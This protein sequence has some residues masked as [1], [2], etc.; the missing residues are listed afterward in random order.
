[1]AEAAAT[2]ILRSPRQ[3]SVTF[4]LDGKA[5]PRL[6]NLFYVRFVRGS[7]AASQS[8]WNKDLGFLVKTVER[9]AISP[10]TEELNQYNKKRQVYTGYKASPVRISVY[11]TADSLCQQM[12]SEYSQYY[13]GDFG[14]SI[15]TSDF[16]YDVTTPDFKDGDGKGFGFVPSGATTMSTTTSTTDNNS[17]FFFDRIQIFQVWKGQY[18]QW[19]LIN[20]R[21]TSFD[22]DDLS[23]EDSQ[24][25]LVNM[26][27]AYEAIIMANKGAPQAMSA[28]SVLT[29]AFKDLRLS[30]DVFDVPTVN[31]SL[32]ASVFTDATRVATA[33]LQSSLVQAPSVF[34]TYD[35]SQAGGALAS[36]GNYDFGAVNVPT[37]ALQPLRS[38]ATDLSLQS[39]AN[40][41]LAAALNIRAQAQ[42]PGLQASPLSV[43]AYGGIDAATYDVARAAVMKVSRG[44][45]DQEAAYAIDAIIKSALAAGAVASGAYDE[46]AGNGTAQKGL[47]LSP[48]AMGIMNAQGSPT[49]QICVNKD[50]SSN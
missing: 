29:E 34:R 15:T 26:T 8:D 49:A 37:A 20:P 30:G 21:I 41:A 24:A 17:Q 1:M 32:A 12:W 18:I 43:S 19:D 9:P 31:T 46:I 36:Y 35:T 39:L 10:T 16:S 33:T 11:D 7:S 6:K 45:S 23:Y 50:S 5:A 27:F 44:T 42:T 14:H 2:D 28:S 13:F 48:Q 3:A 4:S 47:S 38:L 22:P 40:P 25:A